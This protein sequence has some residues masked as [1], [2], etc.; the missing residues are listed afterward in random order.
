MLMIDKELLS[1]VKIMFHDLLGDEL[2]VESKIL[3]H[4]TVIMAQA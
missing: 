4:V 2:K 1:K 3:S